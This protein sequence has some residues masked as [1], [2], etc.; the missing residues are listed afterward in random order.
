M[1]TIPFARLALAGAILMLAASVSAAPATEANP[2]QASASSWSAWGGEVGVRWNH[3]LL[4]ALG[5][6]LQAPKQKLEG[7][8]WREHERF[9]V[10][11]AGSLDFRAQNGNLSEI[12]GGSLQA[13]GG[14]VLGLNDGGNV[15]LTDFR[16]RPKAND[17]LV[18]EL[19]GADGKAWFYIDRL[20]YELIDDNKTLAVQASD[21]RISA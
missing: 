19:V 12:T 2:T 3:E 5:I 8:S 7:L 11:R 15:D 18:L 17:D 21:L 4:E 20:M 10:R 6:T 13:R 14:Y 16:L 1:N 9:D